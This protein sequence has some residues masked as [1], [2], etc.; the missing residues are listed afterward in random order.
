VCV[1][2][3]RAAPAQDADAHDSHEEEDGHRDGAYNDADELLVGA[4]RCRAAVFC[5]AHTSFQCFTDGFV[6]VWTENIEEF[7]DVSKAFEIS[8]HYI[9]HKNIT[10]IKTG[11]K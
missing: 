8:L 3:A 9:L 7:E 1:L 6:F 5:F 2:L 10:G 4:S 11:R